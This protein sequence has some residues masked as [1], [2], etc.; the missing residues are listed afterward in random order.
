MSK[1]EN[2]KKALEDKTRNTDNFITITKNVDGRHS[3]KYAIQNV[4][5][6]NTLG[7]SFK[8]LDEVIKE[9]YLTV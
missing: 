6:R 4:V 7:I 9:Y 8:T 3:G 2:V 5:T 1:F